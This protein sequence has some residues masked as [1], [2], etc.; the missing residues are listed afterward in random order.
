MTPYL[1]RSYLNLIETYFGYREFSLADIQNLLND[2]NAWLI[3]DTP[4][5]LSDILIHMI[6]DNLLFHYINSKGLS[7]L[8]LRVSTDRDVVAENSDM[9]EVLL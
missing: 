9:L 7:V 5:K 3:L 4:L 8:R 6:D 1:V 2:D